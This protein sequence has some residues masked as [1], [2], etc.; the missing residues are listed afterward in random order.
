VTR[1]VGVIGAG[2]MGVGI[3]YVFAAAGCPTTVV[4]PDEARR[5]QGRRAVLDRAS[6]GVERGKLDPARAVEFDDLV[7]TA[8]SVAELPE[9]LDLV[10][11]AVPEQVFLK[12]EVLAAAERRS[13]VVLASNTSAL[14]IDEL[15]KPLR[16]PASFLGLHFFNPVW[17]MPLVEIVRGSD[18][19]EQ[20]LARAQHAAELIEKQTIVVT[21]TPGFATSRLGVAIGLE[22]MRML[23]DGVSDAAGIDRAME[24]GYRHP[25]GPLRLTDLVGLDV[26]LDIARN[27][28]RSYGPRFAPPAILVS[29]V[30]AGELGRKSGRGFF[31]WT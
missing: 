9:G 10:V 12:R 3:T 14:S 21:D 16:H 31:D 27:L 7:R 8:A 28:E 13:P 20:T 17:S 15:A 19:D 22:A 6:A 29:K 18:T 26:R 5:E 2:T 23:E 11:E 25:M 30:E 24:L 4:E 1:T